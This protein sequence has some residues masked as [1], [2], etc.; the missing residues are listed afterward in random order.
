MKK[1]I[2]TV[3][4]LGALVP[5][6]ACGGGAGNEDAEKLDK[7]TTHAEFV[8]ELKSV[9]DD[10]DGADS[11]WERDYDRAMERGD[12]A[13]AAV[14]LDKLEPRAQEVVENY[15]DIDPPAEDKAAFG[16]YVDGVEMVSH[17]IPDIADALRD[18]AELDFAQMTLLASR[19]DDAEKKVNGA[20]RELG[21]APACTIEES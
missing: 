10:H 13:D 7:A 5:L 18:T 11:E 20:A 6:A 12:Y 1:A 14:S 16:R 8:K 15:R 21:V 2:G 19:M 3:L 9:C 17:M 4:V